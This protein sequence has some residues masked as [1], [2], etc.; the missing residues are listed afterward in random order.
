MRS[1]R[2]FRAPCGPK[3]SETGTPQVTAKA[4]D[5]RDDAARFQIERCPVTLRLDGNAA[6]ESNGANG[7]VILLLFES[8]AET[9]HIGIAVEEKRAGAAGDGVPVGIAEDRGRG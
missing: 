2:G 1:R 5:A 4:L 3:Q 9:V 6:D 7:V 8:G